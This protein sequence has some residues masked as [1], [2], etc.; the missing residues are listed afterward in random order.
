MD[1]VPVTPIL[2]TIRT[3][4]VGLF[5]AAGMSVGGA[6]DIAAAPSGTPCIES[7]RA[8]VDLSAQQA[9]LMQGG[10]VLYGPARVATGT[11]S[12]PTDIGTYQVFWK[13]R[14]HRSSLFDEAP[15]PYS[16]FYNGDEAFHQG[17]LGTPSHGCVRLAQGAAQTFYNTLHVGDV[18]Q[19]VR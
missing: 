12:A 2:R 9:W 13:D 8:C 16:V 3:V 4:V 19:V 1:R 5:A 11:A 6:T 15:M 14:H 7:A 10:N 18:V 17:S